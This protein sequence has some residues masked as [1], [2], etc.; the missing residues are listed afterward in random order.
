MTLLALAALIASVAQVQ[1]TQKP[2]R[3]VVRIDNKP[4]SVFVYGKEVT[5]PY[6]WPLTTASGVELTRH[7]PMQDF[8]GDPHDHPHHRGVWFAHAKVNGIDFW[9]SDPSYTTKNMGR[10]AVDSITELTSGKS[11]SITADLSWH[12]PDGSELV[13][14]RRTMTFSSGNPRTVDF[15]IALTATADLVFGDEKDGVFGIRLA[16]E[17]E[18]PLASDPIRT[19]QMTASNGC[20]QEKEC[21]GKRADWMDV[22]GAIGGRSV[23][24]A[25]FDNSRNPRHPTYWH[26]RGYGLLAANIFGVKAF[27]EDPSADGAMPLASGKTI[28]FCYRVVLHDGPLD[29]HSLAS[30]YKSWDSAPLR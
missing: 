3:V 29:A 6:L 12:A 9:N 25:V 24:I 28:R 14:E 20:H 18:E 16:H 19:G 15:D 8:D 1:V 21:W 2:D 5:K 30:M 10:I 22:S 17:L 23:G 26:A 11:G 27:T 7:W 13:K 4:A